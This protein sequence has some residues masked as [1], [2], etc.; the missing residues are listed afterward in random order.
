VVP[1]EPVV[2]LVDADPSQRELI[3][4]DPARTA[5]DSRGS[6][7]PPLDP[8]PPPESPEVGKP[9]TEADYIAKY[10]A[11]TVTELQGAG[12]V[13]AAAIRSRMQ[14][15]MEERLQEGK[16]TEVLPEFDPDGR[17]YYPRPKGSEIFGG[18]GRAGSDVARVVTLDDDQELVAMKKENGWIV[19]RIRSLEKLGKEGR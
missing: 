6:D 13:L 4:V 15:L 12:A 3:L 8:V 11:M 18:S 17:P 2:G 5:S 1:A 14:E 16:Y 19:L 7:S 9:S 10:G